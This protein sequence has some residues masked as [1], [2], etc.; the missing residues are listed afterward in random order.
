MESETGEKTERNF[1]SDDNGHGV[2]EQTEMNI[3]AEETE[4][5]GEPFTAMDYNPMDGSAVGATT[6]LQYLNT[7]PHTSTDNSTVTLT[8][9][10]DNGQIFEVQIN[11]EQV[12]IEEDPQVAGN[13]LGEPITAITVDGA[14][15]LSANALSLIHI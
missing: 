10:D 9:T 2:D 11:P 1:T 14:T 12:M 15:C 5:A 7:A 3:T 4:V 6:L 8:Y 13:E